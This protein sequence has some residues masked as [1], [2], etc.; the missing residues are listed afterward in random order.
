MYQVKLGKDILSHNSSIKDD[1]YY[2][3]KTNDLGYVAGPYAR[4]EDAEA[5]RKIRE[6]GSA[7]PAAAEPTPE[8]KKAEEAK[9]PV[10]DTPATEDSPVPS[11]K[12]DE[13]VNDTKDVKNDGVKDKL[14]KMRRQHMPTP[15]GMSKSK[16]PT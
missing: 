4:P 12:A 11:D 16:K 8:P 14:K 13:E 7:P 5:E 9:A 15:P 1:E 6:A 10:T 2:V 3:T